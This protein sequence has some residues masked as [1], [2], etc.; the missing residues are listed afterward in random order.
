M[1][2]DLLSEDY[3]SFVNSVD[4]L[5]FNKTSRDTKIQLERYNLQLMTKNEIKKSILHSSKK[6]KRRLL[7]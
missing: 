5:N 2:N 4:D 3:E 7:K 6:R 1:Y